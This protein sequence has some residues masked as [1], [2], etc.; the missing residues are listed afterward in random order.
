MNAM[1]QTN[2]KVQFKKGPF[3]QVLGEGQ[4][5]TVTAVYQKGDETDGTLDSL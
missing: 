4:T 1:L 3:T 2:K 5:F